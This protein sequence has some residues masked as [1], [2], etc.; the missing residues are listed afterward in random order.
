M[1]RIQVNQDS[2]HTESFMIWAMGLMIPLKLI[3]S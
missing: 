1:D 3:F 2:A